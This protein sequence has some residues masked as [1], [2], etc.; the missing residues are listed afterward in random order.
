MDLDTLIRD[1]DPAR[2]L[3][4]PEAD[5]ADARQLRDKP[6]RSFDRTVGASWIG[7]AVAVTLAI[8]VIA[9][10]VVGHRQRNP[11]ATPIPAARPI[12]PAAR[13][14]ASILG[15]LRRPQTAA[16]KAAESK[17]LGG[18]A[19]R[20]LVRL[21]A[22]TPWGEQV[23]LAPEKAR[24]YDTLALLTAGVLPGGGV[25][26]SGGLTAASIEAG[27][28]RSL[29]GAGRNFAGGSTGVRLFIVVPDGV[30]KV[31]FVLPRQP[32]PS[33]VPGGPVY[34]HPLA[35]GVPVHNNVAFTQVNRECCDGN[36]V[37]RWYAADG[38]LIRTT[39]NPTDTNRLVA[40][41]KPA[42][43]TPRS[44]AAERNASTPNPVRALPRSG[45]PDSTFRIQWR[46]LL[47]DADYAITASGPIGDGCRGASGINAR[48]G[49]GP[50]DVRGQLYG[51]SIRG[52]RG[53]AAW[54]PGTYHLSVT[55]ID[56]GSAG[57]LKQHPHPFGTAAFTVKR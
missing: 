38:Q 48:F 56:L 4:I 12:P 22:V 23:I 31:V 46:L 29:E 16:D 25:S 32:V 10:V 14:L 35:V 53:T 34:R 45:S 28:G 6:Q 3:V 49:G 41:P 24:T 47:T 55:V 2:K 44:R 15:V 9:L 17:L 57:A 36:L 8:A 43:E 30:A 52:D 18:A 27:E 7:V 42:P 21:A 19:D 1:C 51:E 20:S 5:R 11:P 50:N 54:C 37:T 33:S 13:P 26:S 40:T 39:G